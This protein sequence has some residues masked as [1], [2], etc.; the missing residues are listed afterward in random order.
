MRN[1]NWIW[2]ALAVIVIVFIYYYY[3]TTQEKNK[4]ERISKSINGEDKIL[5]YRLPTSLDTEVFGP[6]YWAALHN[7][8]DEIPCSICR[9]D[10]IGLM[11]GMHDTVN[12]KL[13]KPIYDEDNFNKYTE[14]ICKI[15]TERESGEKK[16]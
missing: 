2:V 12:Y 4:S 5:T 6:H 7:I 16:K 8:V 14:Y 15:K 13:G 1:N 10:A 9:N 3:S 11:K